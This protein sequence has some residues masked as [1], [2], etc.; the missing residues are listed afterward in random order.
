MVKRFSRTVIVKGIACA[1]SAVV[2]DFLLNKKA[3]SGIKKRLVNFR[4]Y[5]GH[6]A[7]EGTEAYRN[8]R[9]SV[10]KVGGD[11]NGKNL[12]ICRKKGHSAADE[13]LREIMEDI[14]KKQA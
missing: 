10:L 11:K 12:S 9:D 3:W 4:D 13:C 14:V 7:V 6:V 2:F 1:V 8:G 5:M